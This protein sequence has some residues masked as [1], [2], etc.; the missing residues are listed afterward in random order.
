MYSIIGGDGKEYGPV[1]VDQVRAWMAAGRA[2]H[3]TKVKLVGSLDWKT[4]A[5]CPEIAGAAPVAN[6]QAVLAGMASSR[7]PVLDVMS[8]YDRSWTL[9]KADFWPI[10]G[11]TF[12][13]AVIH[14]CLLGVERRNLYFLGLIFNK[15]ISGGLF[16]Y[17]LLK[18]RG[19]PA[20][21]G[22]AFAGFKKAFLPLVVIGLLVSIFVTIGVFCLILPG[23][24]LG[25]AYTFSSIIAVDKG[26]P[27]WDSMEL[28]RR[29]VTKN[30]WRIFGLLLLSIPFVLL[31]ICALG[32]GV[33][34]AFPLIVGAIAYAYE[35]LVNP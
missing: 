3:S 15:V 26:L 6:A 13:I 17:F 8:C 34:I 35:D 32:V 4:I 12:I 7:T 30:W 16:F 31:G 28:S 19:Q 25:V 2:N 23:I 29:V 24:Y 27:F 22:D 14:G 20:T 21:V 5:E 10:V 18:I 11:V 33:F 1:T 9:L